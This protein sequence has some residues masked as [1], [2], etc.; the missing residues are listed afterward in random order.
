[1]PATKLAD[2]A[3]NLYWSSGKRAGIEPIIGHLK[4]DYRLIRNFLKGSV[5]DSI[6]LMLAA[7]AFN[8]KK[9]MRRAQLFLRQLIMSLNYKNTNLKQL[10]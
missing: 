9:W 4:S 2:Q 6:N 10:A 3:H 8:F 1:L 7:A 5:G